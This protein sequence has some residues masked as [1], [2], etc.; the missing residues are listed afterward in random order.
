LFE[1]DFSKMIENSYIDY[2]LVSVQI[3]QQK[4]RKEFIEKL[5]D[6]PECEVRYLLHGTQIDPISKIL[7]GEFKYTKKVFYGMGVYFTG[8]MDCVSFYCGGDSY[9][10]RRDL[11]NKIIPVGEAISC[12]A[13]EIFYDKDKRHKI[14][15]PNF[16]ELDH[17]P[18]YEEIRSNYKDQMVEKNGINFLLKLRL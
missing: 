3:Y 14:Y 15:Y 13:S 7:T 2:S 18:S 5:K 6:C 17:F 4:R 9:S 10:S 1:K 8:V 11:W 16:I 12:I